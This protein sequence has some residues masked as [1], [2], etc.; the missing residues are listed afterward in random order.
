M[1]TIEGTGFDAVMRPSNNQQARVESQVLE[2]KDFFEIMIAQLK[3]QDPTKP[4][5]GSEYLGQLAQFNTVSGVQEL[6]L[7][8]REMTRSLQSLQALQASSLVGRNVVLHSGTPAVVESV[9]MVEGGQGLLVNLEDGSSVD[10]EYI[11]EI[12]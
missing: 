4:L 10:L 2:Q 8:F 3:N 6:N 12:N 5:D 7:S 9:T 1:S 11:R